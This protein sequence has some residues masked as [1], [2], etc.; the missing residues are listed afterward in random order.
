M[1]LTWRGS[2]YKEMLWKCATALTK[3]EF[4]KHMDEVKGYNKK[5]YEWLSKIEPGHWTRSHF[6]G[7]ILYNSLFTHYLNIILA[8]G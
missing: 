5:L 1:N 3:V 8:F 4:Q 2:E 6:S 7:Y